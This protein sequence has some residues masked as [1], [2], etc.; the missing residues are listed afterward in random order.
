MHEVPDYAVETVRKLFSCHPVASKCLDDLI[1]N[2]FQ[3]LELK[4][5]KLVPSRYLSWISATNSP[6]HRRACLIQKE[7]EMTRRK[8]APLELHDANIRGNST[9]KIF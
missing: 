4:Y 6:E 1:Q 9:E 7:N 2:I 3:S 8:E 5:N